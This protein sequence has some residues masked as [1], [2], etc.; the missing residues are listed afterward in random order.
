MKEFSL[1]DNLAAI[2]DKNKK[3]IGDDCA[4]VKVGKQK[5]AL[6]TDS[7]VQDIH[8]LSTCDFYALGKKLVSVNLSDLA[9]CGAKPLFGLCS[10]NIAPKTPK[11]KILDLYRGIAKC[12]QENDFKIIGGNTTRSKELSFSISAV[13]KTKRFVYRCGAKHGDLVFVSGQVGN[14]RLGLEIIKKHNCK[15]KNVFTRSHLLPKARTD[16]VSIIS[17]Y[18]SSAIDISDGLVADASHIAKQ[19]KACI[20]ID[21]KKLPISKDLKKALGKEKA[22]TYGL[23]GGEDYEILCTAHKKHKKRLQACGFVHI[24]EILNLRQEAVLIDGRINIDKGFEHEFF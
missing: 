9:S 22:I 12:S 23:F 5:L 11:K 14:S 17:K 1:I 4:M 3:H 6:T 15:T 7:L 24:G 18:A 13:G 16:L 10:I 8:F 20:N 21:K 19:S 2:V